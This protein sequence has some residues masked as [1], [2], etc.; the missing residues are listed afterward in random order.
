[1]KL[2]LKL[3]VLS[4]LLSLSAHAAY[5][6]IPNPLPVS[7]TVTT[8][9]P[10]NAS[11]NV[12]QVK[13]SAV[14]T[15]SGNKSDATF[16]IVMATDQPTP[17][18]PFKVDGSGFT[19]PVSGVF[20]QSIQPVSGTFFQSIQPISASA[21][22]LP[23]GAATSAKQPALGTAGTA[24]ADV[25]S[26]QGIA[27]MTPFLTDGSAT[28]QPISAASLPLP[29][30]AATGALQATGNTSL[31]SIDS[32]LTNP[33]PVSG[34][35]TASN[36]SVGST[37]AAIPAS[38]TT[39]GGTDGTNLRAIKVSSAG[40][41][42]VDNSANTQ[43]VS[44][45]VTANAGSG[46]MAMSAASLPLPSGASTAAKQPALGTAGSA[47]ADVLTVQGVTS[48]TPL[49]VSGTVTANAGTNL[50]TSAL[51]LD[52]TLTGGTQQ[53]KITDGT[54]VA[55]VK[56][57]S[58]AAGATDKAVVVAISPNNT[59]PVSIATAPVLVAGTAYIG[60]TR[61]TD[62]TNDLSLLTSAPGSDTG[63][64]AM[65]V[66]VISSL[67]STYTSDGGTFTRGS[68][69][70]TPVA[71]IAETSAPTLTNGK[72]AAL[73]LTTAGA[74]RTDSSGVTQPVSG[75]ITANAGTNLN[76]SAL[77]LD[78]T[79]TGGTQQTKITDGTN[80]AT[81]KAASTAAGATDKAVVVA[82]SPNNTVPVSIATA[83]VLV[84]G[85]AYIGK[86]RPTDGTL[87]LT[88]LN[89][90]PGSDSGQ[91]AIPV[92]VV[93]ALGSTGGGPADVGT[94]TAA[95]ETD[96]NRQK[97]TASLRLLDTSQSAS[98]QLVAAKGDQTSG[99]WANVKSITPPTLTV[100][101]QGSTGFGV[102]EMHDAGRTA[103]SFYATNV[104]LGT[105]TT[106]TAI[107]MTKSAGTG[108]TSSAASFVVTSGK[109]FRITSIVVAMRSASAVACVVT[110]NFRI[111]TGGAVT[112][113]S[114]PVVL[115]ASV[116]TSASS[117]LQWDRSTFNIPEG[118]EI[119]GDGTLQIGLTANATFA[120]GTTPNVFV[121][122]IGYEY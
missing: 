10:S 51:A 82:I 86:T 20:W 101:T 116:A 67:S 27:S 73:S 71:G 103:I 112:T 120:S 44:G 121:N 19:Q 117:A 59:V 50:N 74:V 32:K 45:T 105:T 80:V 104:A 55:T 42:S 11:T 93:S 94:S 30:G 17:T 49:T 54:N 84:A 85:T 35:V 31:A 81:V 98:S 113:S 72:S 69:T 107:T 52:A 48:M 16:R 53:T 92:R 15:N 33:L 91:V 89:S 64:V 83:P 110:F 60:K 79:L 3:V 41:V 115:A 99:L 46:T 1:M 26:V 2:H 6:P 23:A 108:A 95:S 40:V 28:V 76:T 100:G 66:R 57:A 9:P 61:P 8:T 14:D 88:L 118:Y 7:G 18:N 22:P 47:S 38:A 21:L 68:S 4:A 65:P 13:G 119:L 12:T 5:E 58:T 122:I 102:Q 77:A 43:P 34:T 39:V 24:S 106:E 97:V 36:P 25:L 111:N 56:A 78:A 29:T 62:G 70:E 96:A 114:T 87:D 90:A 37:G 75:T 109:R 63:Q